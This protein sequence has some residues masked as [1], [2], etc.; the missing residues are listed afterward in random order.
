[1]TNSL[2]IPL[3]AHHLRFTC[4][5][6]EPILWHPFKGSAVRGAFVG[7]LRRTFCPEWKAAETDVIHVQLCPVCQ[8]LAAP[9]DEETPGDVRR[10]YAIRPPLDTDLRYEPGREFSFT[11]TLFGE[12]LLYLPYLVLTAGGMGATGM[13]RKDGNGKR[14]RFEVEHIDGVN[15]LSGESVTLLGPGER[16][17]Q[18]VSAPVTHKQVLAASMEALD[19][20]AGSGNRLA[21]HFYTPTRLTQD[22]HKMEK[23]EPFQMIK[24]AVLR[25]TD[26]AAQYGGGRPMLDGRPLHLKTDIYP[27]ADRVVVVTD[28]TRWWDV[29]GYSGRL[30]RE[31]RLGGFVGRVFYQAEDW[32]PLLPWLLWASQTQVGKNAVK[33]SGIVGLGIG[34]WRLGIGE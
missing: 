28:E 6:V 19:L 18:A 13:G 32:G 25:V 23:P 33:G 15:P 30:E 24:A 4:R 12:S 31:Q 11:I 34:K 3:T 17:V 8:L 7:V 29:S 14:G 26:L 1:M 20:L 21:L 16:M 10:P 9:N 27:H 5:A 22:E 2:S